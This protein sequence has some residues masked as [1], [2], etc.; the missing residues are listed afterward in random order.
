[1]ILNHTFPIDN[2]EFVWRDNDMDATDTCL[3]SLLLQMSHSLQSMDIISTLL[4]LLILLI[5]H[6]VN[7]GSTKHNDDQRDMM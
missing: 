2:S 1:M 6:R 3:G 4:G 5:M 7:Q